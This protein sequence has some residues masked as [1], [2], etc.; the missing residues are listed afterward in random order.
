MSP[1]PVSDSERTL[2]LW[3]VAVP[4]AYATLVELIERIRVNDIQGAGRLVSDHK[5]IA[6][7]LAF[8]LHFPENR[9]EVLS[10][11]VATIV[12][13]SVRGTFIADFSPPE[14]DSDGPWLITS[15]RPLGVAPPTP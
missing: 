5:V 10:Y 2:W 1:S 15:L 6:D 11:N 12:F 14:V 4:S 9:F 8:G 13:R 7:S 3:H